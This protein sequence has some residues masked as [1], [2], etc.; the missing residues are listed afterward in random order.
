MPKPTYRDEKGRT[1][2]IRND[3]IAATVKQLGDFLIIGGYPEDHAKRYAQIAHTVSRWPESIDTL[4]VDDRL[5]EIPGVGGVITGYLQDIIATGTTDKFDD[6]QYGKPPPR[7]VL[8]L[9]DIERLGAKTART[10]YQEHGIDSL[11][12]LCTALADGSL[13][14]IR[15]IGPKMRDTLSKQCKKHGHS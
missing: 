15:G 1:R 10:L 3:E 13:D 12:H 2:W 11:Q 6:D 14:G 5:N 7:S 9:T 8:E 4:A